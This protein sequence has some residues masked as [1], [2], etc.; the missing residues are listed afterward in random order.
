MGN[1]VCRL[2][3]GNIRAAFTRA[4]AALGGADASERRVVGMLTIACLAGARSKI[5]TAADDCGRLESRVASVNY[6]ALRVEV[7]L[8]AAE[9]R[10]IMGDPAAAVAALRAAADAFSTTNPREER[11]RYLALLA[12]LETSEDAGQGAAALTRELER[13]RLSWTDAAYTQWRQRSDVSDVLAPVG[14]R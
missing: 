5:A 3:A 1:G 4:R 12:A 11:W 13:L 8:A 9:G 2:S 7:A 14:K 6:S 10:L